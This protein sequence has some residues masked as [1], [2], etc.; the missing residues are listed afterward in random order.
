MKKLCT[1]LLLVVCLLAGC[2]P[3]Q[4]PV[5]STAPQSSDRTTPSATTASATTTTTQATPELPSALAEQPEA[6]EH[7]IKV[8][9]VEEKKIVEMP[10]EEY[11]YGVVAGEMRSD[12]PQEALRAQAVVARTFLLYFLDHHDGSMYEGA[13]ISTDVAE[14][15][16]YN[17]EGINDSI[18]QAVN[19]TRGMALCYDGQYINAWFHSCAGGK[20]AT[21][22]EG[23][24]YK[25]EN[26]PY[27]QVVD[28]PEEEAPAEFLEWEGAFE[29][30]AVEEA[31][32]QMGVNAELTSVSIAKRGPSG[33]CTQ[34]EIGGKLVSCV[35]LRTALDPK[36]FRSTQLTSVSLEDGSLIVSGKGFGHGVGM[37]QWGAYT[38]AQQGEDYRSI[39]AHYYV[40]AELVNAWE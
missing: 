40:G 9:V 4:P 36:V 16:A 12:W 28:S 27:I 21:A 22:P 20:T 1:G 18:R 25:E 32:E 19:D 29:E 31:L 39:L 15:Q 2:A 30:D 24:N 8:Y 38:M 26:P 35:E 13:D 37:S 34:L 17:A 10:V 3:Q 7:P 6:G 23:L 14:C 5:T 33:R 11:L